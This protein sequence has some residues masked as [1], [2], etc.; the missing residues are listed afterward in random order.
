MTGTRGVDGGEQT[1][2]RRTRPVKTFIFDLI[3]AIFL[4]RQHHKP[5]RALYN[6]I[7]GITNIQPLDPVPSDGFSE[8]VEAICITESGKTDKVT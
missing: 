6:R 1:G 7:I 5:R 3:D 4:R 8:M 2:R